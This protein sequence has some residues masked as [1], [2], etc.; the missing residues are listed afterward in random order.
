MLVSKMYKIPTRALHVPFLNAQN[1]R[2]C[3]RSK[4]VVV[5]QLELPPPRG[6]RLFL[7]RLYAATQDVR[8]M[9]VYYVG[10]SQKRAILIP[11]NYALLF[12]EEMA[13]PRHIKSASV[14]KCTISASRSQRSPT[15]YSALT[16]VD[17][18][19]KGMAQLLTVSMYFVFVQVLKM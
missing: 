18:I 9:F 10:T 5:F 1:H 14:L 8:C 3:L 19:V 7:M 4:V 11:N 6:R 12:P 17:T 15:H 2:R 16:T 13:S